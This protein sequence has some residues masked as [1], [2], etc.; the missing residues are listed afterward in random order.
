MDV[1]RYT[2]WISISTVSTHNFGG[3]RI[4]R[5]RTLVKNN[6]QLEYL[7]SAHHNH[8]TTKIYIGFFYWWSFLKIFGP[9]SSQHNRQAIA[10]ARYFV[11]VRI[12]WLIFWGFKT[13]KRTL[14]KTE[15]IKTTTE[16]HNKMLFGRH[17]GY[18]GCWLWT[19][20]GTTQGQQR[21]KTSSEMQRLLTIFTI[22]W[23]I[24]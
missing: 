17:V 7:S 1:M 23:R 8:Q 3:L 18:M 22:C 2:E 9:H 20:Y 24:I 21:V 12:Q 19:R 6:R 14:K 11:S 15:L 13:R 5:I 10:T 16:Q 4:I